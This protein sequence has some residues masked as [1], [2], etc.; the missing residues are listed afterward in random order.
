MP[1]ALAPSTSKTTAAPTAGNLS[2]ATT[3][4]GKPIPASPASGPGGQ[5]PA[6]PLQ[7]PA[8]PPQLPA[9]PAAKPTLGLA[10]RPAH[11]PTPKPATYGQA[12]SRSEP[13][14]KTPA[15]MTVQPAPIPGAANQQDFGHITWTPEQ[16]KAWGAPTGPGGQ[17]PTAPKY[18]IEQ[19]RAFMSA[20]AGPEAPSGVPM[21]GKN[22]TNWEMAKGGLRP[23]LAQPT[24]AKPLSL[25]PF[26]VAVRHLDYKFGEG[27]PGYTPDLYRDVQKLPAYRFDASH[28]TP[29]EGG[30]AE[31][32]QQAWASN[33]G[34]TAEAASLP[35]ARI[36]GL[37][38]YAGQRNVG[39]YNP[40]FEQWWAAEGPIGGQS[41]VDKGNPYARVRRYAD[42][43]QG[44]MLAHA[45]HK[46][47]RDAEVAAQHRKEQLAEGTGF[48]ENYTNSTPA[49]VRGDQVQKDYYKAL[50]SQQ[51]YKPEE[52]AD[53]ATQAVEID[54]QLNK[55]TEGKPAS[56]SYVQQLWQRADPAAAAG[57]AIPFGLNTLG[58]LAN[59]AYGAFGVAPTAAYGAYTGNWRPFRATADSV[60][61]P[62]TEPLGM[63][64]GDPMALNSAEATEAY[65]QQLATSS[66]NPDNPW[67]QRYGGQAAGKAIQTLPWVAGLVANGIPSTL[68]KAVPAMA[69]S[70]GARSALQVARGVAMKYPGP[71]LAAGAGA[72]GL[73][74]AGAND[75]GLGKLQ[76]QAITNLEATAD[77][78]E[79]STWLRALAQGG[80]STLEHPQYHVANF[81][82]PVIQ[83]AVDYGAPVLDWWQGRTNTPLPSQQ[84]R[85]QQ[86]LVNQQQDDA[87]RQWLKERFTQSGVE[88]TPELIERQLQQ[89]KKQQQHDQAKARWGVDFN[90]PPE[91]ARAEAQQAKA[92]QAAAQQAKAKATAAAT[93]PEA[94][95][96]QADPLLQ[97]LDGGLEQQEINDLI[98]KPE[99]RGAWLRADPQLQKKYIQHIDESLVSQGKPLLS[100]GLQEANSWLSP[101]AWIRQPPS[102]VYPKVREKLQAAF[103]K[104]QFTD[105]E[106]SKLLQAG[107]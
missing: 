15:P 58:R 44:E 57:N 9:A 13:E 106:I 69:A 104:A 95:A 22:T 103:P 32:I 83:S 75:V 20:A 56:D 34:A 23:L 31:A 70:A 55:N 18:T 53:R 68:S 38:E 2:S 36:P 24:P 91:I 105:E 92:Q 71:A 54:Q 79:T 77:H 100:A 50:Y 62:L 1:A 17:M 85:Q 25:N 51:G 101:D 45:N 63:H 90:T 60:F 81:I 86:Q 102:V 73:A 8:T 89:I 5:L 27:L 49:Q 41:D 35:P 29:E 46:S 93:Q 67:Y 4:P 88:A 59:S 30:Q 42:T 78:P 39:V 64:S 10:P 47:S 3:T 52:A 84:L 98:Y 14:P 33:P 48:W 61:S 7:L 99:L 11:R 87:G 28:L 76:Q 16:T 107:Q 37:S 80:A 19:Q 65:G 72:A 6:A 74:Q 26:D 21:T 66:A 40:H 97:I 43:Q 12:G 82:Q 94:A 96:A